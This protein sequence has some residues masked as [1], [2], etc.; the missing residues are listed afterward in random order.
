MPIQ[1]HTM[2]VIA[3]TKKD[4]PDSAPMSAVRAH[5]QNT[6]RALAAKGA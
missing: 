5:Y 4:A 1:P 3:P 2:E 6:R